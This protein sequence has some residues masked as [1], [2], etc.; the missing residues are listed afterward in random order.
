MKPFTNKLLSLLTVC[1][2][3]RD[4]SK[5]LQYL[6]GIAGS[7]EYQELANDAV[8]RSEF[9]SK[10]TIQ[11]LQKLEPGELRKKKEEVCSIAKMLSL[12][13]KA[14]CFGNAA[15]LSETDIPL[16]ENPESVSNLIGKISICKK[17]RNYS[18]ISDK[19]VLRI[20]DPE[21]I[22]SAKICFD[23]LPLSLAKE[24][25]ITEDQIRDSMGDQ[26]FCIGIDSFEAAHLRFR[27]FTAEAETCIWNETSRRRRHRLFKAAVVMTQFLLW[28]ACDQ[29]CLFT[30]SF[31]VIFALISLLIGVVFLIWG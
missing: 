7:D 2:E 11:Q 22:K 18:N 13:R 27:E 30:E 31:S 14:I 19:H 3:D 28:F 16:F 10:W 26:F 8:F 6:A 24:P 23:M 1:A 5:K 21:T 17:K 4:E 20:F 25:V 9:E 29:L 15:D 12:L